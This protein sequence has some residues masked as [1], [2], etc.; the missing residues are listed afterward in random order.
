[1]TQ[2]SR[3]FQT[4]PAAVSRENTAKYL[5]SAFNS[6]GFE[7]PDWFVPDLEDGTAPN[8]KEE[9]LDNTVELVNEFGP[10]FDGEIRPRVQ[11][12]F[13]D[14]Q[15]S[16]SG[17]KEME[18]LVRECGDEMSGVVV[19]KVGRLSDVKMAADSLGRA[20]SD[21]GFAEDTFGLAVIIESP[22]AKSDL[23]EIA[24][25]GR[26]SRLD[27]L[28]FGPVDYTAGIG[29][30][31]ID[32]ERPSWPGLLEDLSNEASAN[33]LVSIGGPFDRLFKQQAGVTYYN[34]DGYVQQVQ[35]E[36][37]VGLSGSWSLHPK[38]TAQANRIHMPSEEELE[39]A[40]RSIERFLEETSTG[41]GAVT[42]DGQMVDEATIKNYTNTVETV[43]AIHETNP[44]QAT[45]VYD[46]TV[47][48]RAL[49]T[50]T[51]SRI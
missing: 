26:E 4:A 42:I 40:V 7:V 51:D 36:A 44:D 2:L 38:Q 1:M 49:T 29:G 37:R 13:D 32:G 6:T 11:W 35:T 45:A 14:E 10:T 41:N 27:G 5:Q 31:E 24:A 19:P 23:R 17:Q 47:L 21:Y 39:T 22:Q 18:A 48:E 9:G 12:A 43:T 34:G 15:L 20:E 46:E 50:D 33:S 3:T 25:F 28:V 8:M 30:R 16:T